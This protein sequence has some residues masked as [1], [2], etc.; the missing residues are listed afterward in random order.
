MHRKM[1][2]SV[3]TCNELYYYAMNKP[4]LLITEAELAWSQDGMYSKAQRCY[5][6][7]LAHGPVL[8]N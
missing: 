4:I 6:Q 7:Q 8:R 3:P 2:L 5:T 1:P